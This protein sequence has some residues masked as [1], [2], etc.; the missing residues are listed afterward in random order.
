[1][2]KINKSKKI[3]D[4][5][6]KK[7]EYPYPL[8]EVGYKGQVEEVSD[9]IAK[10]SGLPQI[11]YLE[12]VEFPNDTLGVAINLEEEKVGVIVLGDYLKIHEG[13]KVKGKNPYRG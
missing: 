9:G 5:I 10:L 13:D 2:P 3:R 11:S 4:D 1:M 7:L 8:Y 12:L 6:F